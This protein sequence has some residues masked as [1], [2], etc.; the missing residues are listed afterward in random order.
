MGGETTMTQTTVWGDLESKVPSGSLM[1]DETL[2]NAYALP[3]NKPPLGVAKIENVDMLIS[4]VKWAR[5]KKCPLLPVSSKAPHYHASLGMV[6]DAVIAD[7]SDLRKVTNINRR[8]RVAIFEAG[9]TF[10]ELVPLAFE[11][12]LRV[13]L[14]LMPRQGKSAL[15]AYLDREPVIYPS[16]QWDIS[17]PLLCLEAVYG[18]GD[19]FRTGSAAGPGTIE[20]QWNAGEFQKGP[21]GPGQ[22]DWMKLIQGAQGGIALATWCSAKCEVLP[23][24]EKLFLAG[25]DSIEPLVEAAYRQFFRKLT[26]IHFMVDRNAMATLLTKNSDESENIM[27]EL[28]PWNMVYSVSGV[29]Y[30]PEERLR[31]LAREAEKELKNQGVQLKSPP[32]MSGDEVLK[33]LRGA[34]SQNRDDPYWKDRPLGAHRSV[35]FQTT[36]DRAG[37]YI[38]MFNDLA[39]EAG[40]AHKRISRYLQPQVG[41]RCCHLEF[42]VSADPK[43][44]GDLEKVHGF[45][46]Q[47][48]VPLIESG[49]F[50]SRPH[51][52][53]AKPAMN[54]A[55]TSRVIF[56]KIKDIFDPDHILAP[57]RL[58]LGGDLY[59]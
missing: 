53:W 18:T 1:N 54:R 39:Q 48:A 21:M 17:D 6:A 59:G 50:F 12:G 32:L 16:F 52:Q 51:G 37:H 29:E 41:G 15:A 44:A 58:M 2:R 24:M 45:C 22:Q 4:L 34:D 5:E 36:M 49:A 56:Q 20:D 55:K 42:I 27:K 33:M 19:P 11:Q 23:K 8:N 38:T 3:G 10:D 13:M 31:Y 9:V 30:F 26:D 47:V 25:A 46:Q 14:P 57:G 35:Y 40:I 43:D 28:S 7:F